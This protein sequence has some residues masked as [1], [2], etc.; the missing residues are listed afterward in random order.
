MVTENLISTLYALTIAFVISAV[1]GILAGTIIGASRTLRDGLQPLITSWLSTPKV[2]FIP[3][4]FTLLGFGL[5]YRVGNALIHGIPIITILIIGAIVS[6]D[7]NYLRVAKIYGASRLQVF[8]KIYLQSSTL[9]DTWIGEAALQYL[10]HQHHLRRAFRG[11]PG[12]RLPPEHLSANPANSTVL[13]Y[14]I[15]HRFHQH[16]CE[17]PASGVRTKAGTPPRCGTGLMMT[18]IRIADPL[19]FALV[20]EPEGRGAH[21][22]GFVFS[23]S[24]SA[25]GSD[26]PSLRFV[27]FRLLAR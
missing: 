19:R 17:P 1:V 22:T 2:M 14:R 13:C 3:L 5:N 11:G 18:T 12:P 24:S 16:S 21:G 23:A 20:C 6:T 8:T 15:S 10:S 26:R 7:N 4:L 9:R 27:E 25:H